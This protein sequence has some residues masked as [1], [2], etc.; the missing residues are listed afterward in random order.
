MVTVVAPI[1]GPIRGVWITENYSWE[2]I[3]FINV[4]I[5]IFVSFVVAR[6]LRG[7]PERL[8]KPRMAYVGLA[9]LVVGVGALQILLD[10]G[11]DEDWFKSTTIVVLRSEERRVGKECVRTCKSRGSP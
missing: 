6:Q 11:H 9:T 8:D 2:W 3:F 5:G 4:P 10:L 7:R 1:A